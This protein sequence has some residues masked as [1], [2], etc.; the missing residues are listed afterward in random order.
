[1]LI[2]AF[3]GD[4]HALIPLYMVGVFVSFSLSQ[5]GHGA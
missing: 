3:R 5:A 4:T 1:M 2:V